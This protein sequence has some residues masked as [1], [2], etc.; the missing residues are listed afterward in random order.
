L[1]KKQYP[2]MSSQNLLDFINEVHK[3]CLT[4][5][6]T[7]QMRLMGSG[8]NGD[9]ELTTVAGTLSYDIDTDNGFSSDVW[10]VTRVYQDDSFDSPEDVV[11]FDATEGVSAKV[12]FKEDPGAATYNMRCYKKPTPITSTSIELQILESHVLAYFYPGVVSFIE[13]LTN[14]SFDR[15]LTFVEKI[16]PKISFSLSVGQRGNTIHTP[17][18]GY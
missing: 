9:S 4:T 13:M 15:W 10:R 16:A 5:R 14:G 17:Y 18:K 7:A 11:C 12:V 8:D 2:D 3:I 6:P 1:L